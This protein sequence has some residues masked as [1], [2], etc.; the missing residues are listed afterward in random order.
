MIP[1]PSGPLWDWLQ[2]LVDSTQIFPNVDEDA[3]DR[4]G[5]NWKTVG[6]AMADTIAAAQAG[7]DRIPAVWG[8]QNGQLYHENLKQ[9]LGNEG[10]Q[11]AVRSFEQMSALCTKF[12]TDVRQTKNQIWSELIM[13]GFFFA[14]TFLLPPGIGD[15]FRWRLAAMLV[16]RFSGLIR[17]AAELTH[18]AAG[19]LGARA[20]SIAGHT[21][22][23]GV[24]EVLTELVAQQLDIWD[25]ARKNIDWQQVKISALAGVLGSP[26]SMGLNAGS[27]VARRLVG[28]PDA[29]RIE[30]RIP[31]ILQGSGNAFATNAITSPISS[32]LAKYLVTGQAPEFGRALSE[33]WFQAGVLGAS[34]VHSVHAG[35]A[36]GQSFFNGVREAHGIAP[37]VDPHGGPPT[38]PTP[39]A[40]QNPGAT[41]QS[42]AAANP[43][44]GTT[45]PAGAAAGAG[46]AVG[47]GSGSASGGSASGGANGGA[48]SG[49]PGASSQDAHVD[50]HAQP[51]RT[52]PSDQ[53]HDDRQQNQQQDQPHQ[54]EEITAQQP[55]TDQP[56]G[57]GD[58]HNAANDLSP[59]A[60]DSGNHPVQGEHVQNHV[61]QP[62]APADVN[63]GQDGSGSV[64]PVASGTAAP[65]A[66][67]VTGTGPHLA[68][69]GPAPTAVGQQ[70]SSPT[71]PPS[72]IPAVQKADL[73]E[74]TAPVAQGNTT[75][76]APTAPQNDVPRKPGTTN[77]TEATEATAPAADVDV[78]PTVV[79]PGGAAMVGEAQVQAAAVTADVTEEANDAP[80]PLPAHT[81]SERSAQSNGPG[82]GSETVEDPGEVLAQD[83]DNVVR[84]TPA[85]DSKPAEVRIEFRGANQH[86]TPSAKRNNP[87]SWVAGKLGHRDIVPSGTQFQMWA[88]HTMQQQLAALARAG[89]S[90]DLAFRA[91]QNA[92]TGIMELHAEVTLYA[93]GGEVSHVSQTNLAEA[94]TAVK[95]GAFDSGHPPAPRTAPGDLEV[96]ERPQPVLNRAVSPPPGS[97]GPVDPI[98]VT[99]AEGQSFVAAAMETLVE[100]LNERGPDDQLTPAAIATRARYYQTPEVATATGLPT[101]KVNRWSTSDTFTVV[102]EDGTVVEVQ[103][104]GLSYLTGTGDFGAAEV[105]PAVKKDGPPTDVGLDELGRTPEHQRAYQREVDLWHASKEAPPRPKR[106]KQPK[107]A[108]IV[109]DES[110]QDEL[111][112]PSEAGWTMGESFADLLLSWLGARNPDVEEVHRVFANE[113]A[114][115]GRFDKIFIRL[116]RGTGR[117]LGFAIG[118]AKSVNGEL[119]SRR[120][121]HDLRYE[122]GHRE[123]IRSILE[124]MIRR[125]GRTAVLDNEKRVTPAA[126]RE[127][128]QGPVAAPAQPQTEV[129]LDNEIQLAEAMLAA[130]DAGEVEFFMVKPL[131]ENG[132]TAVGIT[133]TEFDLTPPAAADH[134]HVHPARTNQDVAENGSELE[135]TA[136]TVEEIAA[137]AGVDLSGIDVVIVTDPAEFADMDQDNVGASAMQLADGTVQILLGPA[138]FADRETL[139]ATLAHEKTHADQFRAGRP[140]DDNSRA[141]LEREAYASEAA[142]VERVRAHDGDQVHDRDDVRPA[143]PTRHHDARRAPERGGPGR[144]SP[145]DRRHGSGSDGTGRGIPLHR[146]IGGN[147]D[148]A[149]DGS[150]GRPTPPPGNGSRQPDLTLTFRGARVGVFPAGVRVPWQDLVR[151]Q[152]AVESAVRRGLEVDLTFVMNPETKWL[153]ATAHVTDPATDESVTH[154]RAAIAELANRLHP[155]VARTANP[156][157]PSQPTRPAEPNPPAPP[158]PPARSTRP[159]EPTPSARPGGEFAVGQSE[160]ARGSARVERPRGD[161]FLPGWLLVGVEAARAIMAPE[162][163]RA[164]EIREVV[165]FEA[166]RYQVTTVGGR[167]FVLHVRVGPLGPTTVAHYV[168]VP[169]LTPTAEVTLSDRMALTEVPQVLARVLAETAAATLNPTPVQLAATDETPV[170][171][172]DSDPELDPLLKAEDHGALAEARVLAAEHEATASAGRRRHIRGVMAAL[173]ASMSLGKEQ[174][175]SDLLH[176]MIDE[177]DSAIAQ[178]FEDRRSPKDDRVPVTAYV[179]KSF[180]GSVLSAVL[181]GSAGYL[182]THSIVAGV[183]LSVPTIVNS[184][185]GAMTER[186]LDGRK[187]TSRQ[188]VYDADRAARDR[189]YPGMKGLLDGAPVQDPDSA[190]QLPR[191]TKRS[192]YVVRH[193]VPLLAAAGTA[194][195]LS[196]ASIPAMPALLAIGL[197]AVAKSLAERRVDIKTFGFRLGRADATARRQLANP[198]STQNQLLALL[199]DYRS[200]LAVLRAG[201]T[202]NTAQPTG[203]P[204]TSASPGTPGFSIQAA[205]EAI[206]NV[207]AAARRLLSHLAATQNQDPAIPVQDN[208]PTELSRHVDLFGEGLINA[209]GPAVTSLLLGVVGDK[210]FVNLEE[211]ASD[212]QRSW[213]QAERDAV[214]GQALVDVLTDQLRQVD[215]AIRQL[216]QLIAEHRPGVDLADR[217]ADRASFP[218]APARP[219]GARPP[220]QSKYWVY[221]Q[222]V[223]FAAIGAAGGVLGLDYIFDLDHVSVVVTVAGAVGGVTGTPVARMLFRRAELQ[224]KDAN[225]TDLAEQAVDRHEL[226]RQAAIGKYLTAQLL[227]QIQQLRDQLLKPGRTVAEVRPGDPEYT[228]RVRAAA[229]RAYLDNLTPGQSAEKRDARRERVA[230]LARIDR[231]AAA[232]D[233]AESAIEL[234]GVESARTQLAHAIAL[235]E[236]IVDEDG[237]GKTFPDLRQVSPDRGRRVT[238]G[239]TDQVRAGAARALGRMLGESAGKPLLEER[240]VALEEIVRAADAIDGHTATGTPESLAYVEQQLTDRIAAYDELLRQAD[241]PGAF[242]QPAISPTPPVIGLVGDSVRI[243]VTEDGLSEVLPAELVGD[244]DALAKLE[245]RWVELVRD[246][247]QVEVTVTKVAGRHAVVDALEFTVEVTD[248]HS[249]VAAEARDVYGP[250]DVQTLVEQ[251]ITDQQSEGGRHRQPDTAYLTPASFDPAAGPASGEVASN[252]SANRARWSFGTPGRA[253]EVVL[254][255]HEVLPPERLLNPDGKSDALPRIALDWAFARDRAR[256]LIPPGVAIS[257]QEFAELEQRVQQ[258][259]ADGHVVS[260]RLRVLNGRLVVDAYVR[261]V[262]TGRSAVHEDLSLSELVVALDN[263]VLVTAVGVAEVAVHA[264]VVNLGAIHLQ[265]GGVRVTTADGRQVVIS[266]EILARITVELGQPGA[267]QEVLDAEAVRRVAEHLGVPA[268]R[269]AAQ[270]PADILRAAAHRVAAAEITRRAQE[271]AGGPHEPHEERAVNTRSDGGRGRRGFAPRVR[272]TGFVADG[273]GAQEGELTVGRVLSAVGGVLGADLGGL[274]VG[275]PAV[276]GQ[277]VVVATQHFQV[278]VGGVRWGKVASTEVH[279]GTAE[280]PHVVTF[281]AGVSDSQLARVW[282]H[283]LSHTLQELRAPE[284]GP[285]RRLR[286]RLTGTGRNACVDAQFNEF[287]YLQRQWAMGDRPELRQDIEGLV[288]AI[289]KRGYVP[290]TLPWNTSIAP[291]PR[292]ELKA[293]ITRQLAGLDETIASLN[294]LIAGKHAAAKEASEAAQEEIEKRDQVAKDNGATAR[295][296]AAE[297]EIQKQT[298]LANWHNQ[299]AAD[300]QSALARLTAARAGYAQLLQDIATATPRRLAA[301]AHKFAAEVAAYQE[302]LEDL[303]PPTAALPSMQPTGRLPHLTALTERINAILVAK[304]IDHTFT[305]GELQQLLSAEV[306]RILTDDGVVLRVGA[307]HPADLRIK[308]SVDEL[309]EVRDPKVKASEVI[310]GLFPQ[311][312]RRLATAAT[313]RFGKTFTV[314]MKALLQLLGRVIH[315]PWLGDLTLK[316]E[317]G[318]AHT[319]TVT[320]NAAEFSQTGAVEDNRGE[321]VL[322]TGRA[323]WQLDV[324]TGRSWSAAGTVAEGNSMDATELRAWVSHAYTVDAARDLDQRLDLA[325]GRLPAHLLTSVTGLEALTDKVIAENGDHLAKLGSD[326]TQVED[327]LHAVLNDDLPS[328][329]AESTDHPVLRPLTVDGKPVGHVEVTTRIRYEK[330]EL[331]GGQST[332]HWQESVRIGFSTASTQ[333]SFGASASVTLKA[334]YDGDAVHDI[335]ADGTDVGPTVSGGR[336]ATRS[337]ALSGGGTSIHVGVHRFTGPTQAYSMVLEHVVKVVLDGKAATTPGDSTVVARVRV[338]DAYRYGL[339]VDRNAVH[340]G[341]QTV[342]GEVDPNA[343][344]PGRKLEFP[345]WAKDAAGRL[346]AA[347]P[348]N[349]QAVTGAKA[350]FEAIMERMAGRGFVPPLDTNGNPDLTKLS[351]DPIERHAQ[352]LNLEELREQ[353]STERL[354]A[355]Y[356]IATRDGILITLTHAR[357]AQATETVVLRIGI[358]PHAS[359]PLGVTNNEAVVLLNIGSE[360]S[361]RSATR[362]KV[363]PWQADPMSVSSTAGLDGKA[364][365]SYGRQALGRV[366]SWFTGSTVNQVTLIESTSPVAVFEVNHT[367]SVAEGEETFYTSSPDE[368][369]RIL[370]D[371][372]LL[373]YDDALPPT[374]PTGPVRPSVL[375]RMTLLALGAADFTAKLPKAIRNE[376]TALQQLGVFL[377]PRNLLSHPEWLG[378]GYGTTL[379]VPGI[380]GISRRI[381]VS[382]TGRL[383]NAQ[384]VAVTEGVSGDINLALGSH[385]SA[386]GRSYGGSTQASFGASENSAGGGV[387]ASVG[388]NGSTSRTDQDIWGVERLTIETGRH[389]VFTADVEAS[390]AVGNQQSPELTVGTV[391]QLAER[392]ALRFYAQNELALPLQQVADAVERFLHGHLKLDRRAATGLVRRYRA[393]LAA[394]RRNGTPVPALSAEHSAQA[395]STKLRPSPRPLPGTP[396]ERLEQILREEDPPGSRCRSTTGS[397]WDSA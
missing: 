282:V 37:Y 110:L 146:P 337:E 227:D 129:P 104:P 203:V 171:Q 92:E 302:A 257:Q 326:R 357:T 7:N 355:G 135:R 243:A 61:E 159:A 157:P 10:Y 97:R 196:A 148:P 261:E 51:N 103:V 152:E 114:G 271:L 384:L 222:Q 215:S 94:A 130:L 217:T 45:A 301:E 364:A 101:G 115:S 57:P 305:A 341:G 389:Y 15:L 281:A 85:R 380:G 22:W 299:I 56:A 169:G 378:T 95:R 63:G 11:E 189:Q 8:D 356:D 74:T 277:L 338:K 280:D 184:L 109:V 388:T 313:S 102:A 65:A 254:E 373:P 329:L 90:F 122:Q 149:D 190:E 50:R 192:D 175:N 174:P 194:V 53:Q 218:V 382:L 241:L 19:G 23:E 288:N 295:R 212:A 324:R 200:Q 123:Y 285:L 258:L 321:S 91:V 113:Y 193:A 358:E 30:R 351:T 164:A 72:S 107:N 119:G 132:R 58:S 4:M 6:K 349:V 165:Q 155:T 150:Q 333:Q 362:S 13:N 138:S 230:A 334:G 120:G 41:T 88:F 331:V 354:E 40:G 229:E 178:R 127:L 290:P 234:V 307:K 314:P 62:G 158:S 275:D 361:S 82:N 168:A 125:G 16:E 298:E 156:T 44:G 118:E 83:G 188:P 266:A 182:A 111:P 202:P 27:K 343:V 393:D 73:A 371:S 80:K 177:G 322:Y 342:D 1:E 330:V 14:L 77:A 105:V 276:V 369:A 353:L 153:E 48:S 273:R 46:S 237:S 289:R 161:R 340:N 236:G 201:T 145:P 245:A 39:D 214:R 386:T 147:P 173:I 260:V 335:A 204:D 377:N 136:E 253:D 117:I 238:G 183:A 255:L 320:G 209:I 397:T 264:A 38:T 267:T 311:G 28:L 279:A 224:R 310:N 31:Y 365:L 228:D 297:A 304:G 121:A 381:A 235:Y 185:V 221:L 208:D 385:G 32:E 352:L 134:D 108:P 225:A 199:V 315:Q 256:G 198:A 172:P 278:R 239:P 93:A 207:T 76:A 262:A 306:G 363:W 394:A 379:L 78:D 170:L 246:G 383:Q 252:Q 112:I 308:L 226:N 21:A 81:T 17:A 367:L 25:G 219:E 300:Y 233:W 163:Q 206:D 293:A 100:R 283:E 98:P 24:E 391:F 284:G 42:P 312:G 20:L 186:W 124:E 34:R 240:L 220:G 395:L 66:T 223:A 263:Q 197:S 33:G 370:I 64:A 55:S 232:L 319:R 144:H 143:E 294:A 9:A 116:E 387:N 296:R 328:R 43:S 180:R 244:A 35:D 286:S 309:V 323:S 137:I 106:P 181:I 176:T 12:A 139:A 211:R 36:M 303:A 213:D 140:V 344:V 179:V 87:Y 126:P 18:A 99:P 216:K 265:D 86:G 84:R 318:T 195:A 79:T 390:L 368:T 327:Q 350:A 154:R 210:I 272:G 128:G 68:G 133:I 49:H 360:T 366:L 26:M 346:N 270:S 274:G 242:P 348:W 347:G 71:A 59:D 359:K 142:A 269:P 336:T 54:Y 67:Q 345:A 332:T 287:R 131:L 69:Q 89:Q 392:E 375:Q 268:S 291:D 162:V 187:D 259:I 96:G 3:A 317:V 376:A 167:T 2:K 75:P 339:P 247:Y 166:D 60:V 396:E 231:L 250:A 29:T 205:G 160:A 151:L 316:G 141:E 5:A 325:N 372:D 248:P 249:T 52:A 191:A 47:A 292:A 70:S 251:M 374:P